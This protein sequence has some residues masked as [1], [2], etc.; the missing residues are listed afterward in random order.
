[1]ISGLEYVL[2]HIVLTHHD[3]KKASAITHDQEM[4]L[5]ARP[6]IVQ[7]A[8]DGDG[9]PDVVADSVDVNVAHT[10]VPRVPEVPQ[11]P[12]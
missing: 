10:K 9:L 6:S 3:L 2:W 7:P 1:M 11:V 5:A 12:R 4:D 8:F